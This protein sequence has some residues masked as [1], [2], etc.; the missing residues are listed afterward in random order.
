MWW[1]SHGPTVN[2]CISEFTN[3]SG[4][5]EFLAPYAFTYEVTLSFAFYPVVIKH[6]LVVACEWPSMLKF[7]TNTHL[8][9]MMHLFVWF[10]SPW[11]PTGM[12]DNIIFT[13]KLGK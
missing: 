2:I 1:L 13:V 10:F 6:L 7:T 4:C 8:V 11:V 12:T 9:L 5:F 3:Q